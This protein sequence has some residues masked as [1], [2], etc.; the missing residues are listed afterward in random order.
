MAE[1]FSLRFCHEFKFVLSQILVK[2][3]V[4]M[5]M[6]GELRGKDGGRSL[7]QKTCAVIT[8]VGE[9]KHNQATL[10]NV[11]QRSCYI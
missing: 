8:D 10:E 11:F 7:P 6:G 3:E 4:A 9:D 5:A 1:C 2:L